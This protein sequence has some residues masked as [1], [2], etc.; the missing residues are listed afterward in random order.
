MAQ[1]FPGHINLESNGLQGTIMSEDDQNSFNISEPT[2][3]PLALTAYPP[4]QVYQRT[5]G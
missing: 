3:V 4:N 2:A 5:A 1:Q